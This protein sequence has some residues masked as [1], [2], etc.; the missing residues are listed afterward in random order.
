MRRVHRLLAIPVLSI[1]LVGCGSDA[2][3]STE[4]V[5]DAFQHQGYSL[6]P[7]EFPGGTIATPQGDL[8][9]PRG[10]GPFVVVVGL[11][12]GG[13]RAWD[14]YKAQQTGESFTVRRGDVIAISDGGLSGFD[15]E[16]VVDAMSA[17][18]DRGAEVDIAGHL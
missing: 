3:Y 9:I 18:P 16:R 7:Q 17:L 2:K 14:D 1:A 4:E 12:E 15:R 13:D 11:P 8:L 5:V 6:V 10:G